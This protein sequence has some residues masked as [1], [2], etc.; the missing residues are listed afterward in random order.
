[1]HTPPEGSKFLGELGVIRRYS[2]W[3]DRRVR[4]IAADNNIDLNPRW[5][6]G[7]KTPL[8][9]VLP[10]AEVIKERRAMQRHEVALKVEGAI[11]Q[12]AVEDFVTPPPAAFVKGCSDVTFAAYTRWYGEKK[13]A[14]RK[15]VM[16][17]ARTKSSNGCRVEICLF[18]SIEN[19]A[20]YL[21][22]SEAEAPMWSSSSTPYIEE[23][24]VNQ[25]KERA[26]LYD[27]DESIAVEILRTINN[28]GM[29]DKYVFKRTAS[30]EW[31]GEVY[32]DVELD[33]SRWTLKPGIDMPEPFDRIVIGAPLWVRSHG[34]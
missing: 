7:F 1:M 33:K 17:H 5:Q 11:G 28:Q 29:L 14:K 27:D 10:Q 16:I 13:K 31:F 6:L 9:S 30:A 15:A 12:I 26:K 34:G 21:T 24:I 3:S 19:C 22:G 25:G 2:Y 4:D 32:H 23:F 18:A 8:L 20:G